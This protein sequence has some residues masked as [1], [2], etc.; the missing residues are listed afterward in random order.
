[1]RGFRQRI[2]SVV[3]IPETIRSSW[4]PQCC[5]INGEISDCLNNTR[6]CYVCH[7]SLAR[8]LCGTHDSEGDRIGHDNRRRCRHV[9]WNS[10][11]VA[12][13]RT[14]RVAR[15]EESSRAVNNEEWVQR[16]LQY[17]RIEKGV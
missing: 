4:I 1:D 12:V 13:A 3:R 14:C 16:F 11:P 7:D 15:R 8:V 6:R 9:F 17:L 2:R 10:A 5:T